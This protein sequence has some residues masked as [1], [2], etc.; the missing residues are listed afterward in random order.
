MT[1]GEIIL[2]VVNFIVYP[3]WHLVLFF[4]ILLLIVAYSFYNS[5]FVK[6]KS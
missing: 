1:I 6:N 5:W 3:E 2:A 4:V